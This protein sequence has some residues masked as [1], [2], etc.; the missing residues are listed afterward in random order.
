MMSHSVSQRCLWTLGAAGFAL[1]VSLGSLARFAAAGEQEATPTS[2]ADRLA[3]AELL[4]GLT[5]VEG[6]GLVVTLRNSPRKPSRGVDRSSLMIHEQ[7]VSAVLNALR[8]AGAEAIAIGS[9]ELPLERILATTALKVAPGGLTV[10]GTSY[11]PPYQIH[12][13][14]DT[15]ALREELYQAD[16]VVRQAGLDT[17]QMVQVEP[18]SRLELPAAPPGPPFR[19]AAAPGSR[20]SRP[21]AQVAQGTP[22][23][24]PGSGIS[25]IVRRGSAPP[26]EPA[27][28]APPSGGSGALLPVGP[29]FSAQEAGRFH[30]VGC[31]FGERIERSRRVSYRTARDARV[32]GRLPCPVCNPRDTPEAAAN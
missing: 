6:P 31:R 20:P 12:A 19:F 18:R 1:T 30:C 10:R 11:R 32:A 2:L 9:E 4:A 5:P 16:G 29:F 28:P 17:L 22:P 3:R 23:D 15:E 25:G 13:I 21:P 8:A 27:R 7:D 26:S 24:R 14:G